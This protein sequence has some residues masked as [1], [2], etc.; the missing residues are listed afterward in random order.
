M[1]RAA[2]AGLRRAAW[3]AA[4]AL[5]ACAAPGGGNTPI[6]EPGA[7]AVQR[8]VGRFDPE[9][10]ITLQDF[11]FVGTVAASQTTAFLGTTG[12]VERYD[13]LRDRWL[14]PLTVADGLPDDQVTALAVDRVGNDVWIGTRRG[15]V[16]LAF[17]GTVETAWGPP[18]TTVQDLRIDPA[19]GS[20]YAFVAGGWWRGRGGSPVFDRSEAPPPE[21]RGSV[22]VQDVDPRTFPWTDPFH[23]RS[24]ADPAQ[25]FRLTRLTRDLRGDIYAGTWGDNGRRWGA[26]RADWEALYF[27]LGGPP[28]G[29]VARTTDGTWFAAGPGATSATLALA[30][31]DTSGRWSYRVPGRIP[32]L[33]T[34]AARAL[35]ATG[36]TLWLGSDLGLSRRVG[37]AWTTWGWNADPSIGAVTALAADGD[38]LWV[39]TERGLLAFDPA[40]GRGEAVHL[41]GRAITAL[42]ALPG[43]VYVGSRDGLWVGVRGAEADSF[44]Q[45]P[46]LGSDVRA[47]ARMG[48]LLAVG[49]A[50]GLEVRPLAGGEPSRF[51]AGGQLPDPPLSL[52]ADGEGFWIGTRTG[53]VRYR[54]ATGEWQRFG[55]E[56]GLAGAPVLHLLAEENAVWASSRHGV[57]RFDWRGAG[58]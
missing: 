5:A 8:S 57:T 31:A 25:V 11:R 56:D 2:S 39:G 14:S 19:D 29:P 6:G 24:P 18:P 38:R 21:A 1:R 16:H 10:W 20:V 50:T 54:P 34:A 36:D 33:P 28:G 3:T 47:L 30:F 4:L 13:T 26:S 42:L 7:G 45:L 44:G 53:L 23:V 35:L 43:T 27:G 41:R 51:L 52:A 46:T 40:T 32:G 49:T 58:R 17:D 9:A 12:G 22:D 37:E 55:P 15:L 48:D